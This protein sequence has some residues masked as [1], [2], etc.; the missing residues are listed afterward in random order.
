MNIGIKYCG[1]CNPKYNRKRFVKYIKDILTEDKF[2]V[3]R[4]NE[5]YGVLIIV[6]GCTSACANSDR[7]L[8]QWKIK[9]DSRD[10]YEDIF[11]KINML[12]HE[13]GDY[14]EKNL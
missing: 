12:R 3:A 5:Y 14:V 8:C 7:I 11:K 4:E 13:G 1:G 10:C 9:V 2:F 6:C